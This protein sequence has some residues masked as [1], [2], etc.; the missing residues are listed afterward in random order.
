MGN[1][2]MTGITRGPR[3]S[4]PTARAPDLL[5]ARNPWTLSAYESST[6]E[7][8]FDELQDIYTDTKD[9]LRS[10][11]S[12]V[13]PVKHPNRLSS[14]GVGRQSQSCPP[15]AQVISDQSSSSHKRDATRADSPRASPDVQRA[16]I[17]REAVSG[18]PGLRV[19]PIRSPPSEPPNLPPS[20]PLSQGPKKTSSMSSL[21]SAERGDS[22]IAASVSSDERSLSRKSK[23]SSRMSSRSAGKPRACSSASDSRAPSVKSTGTWEEEVEYL[24][25]QE[26]EST[27]DFRWRSAVSPR[28]SSITDNDGDAHPSGWI[29][30]SPPLKPATSQMLK[31]AY[32]TNDIRKDAATMGSRFRKGTSIGHRGFLA[33]RKGPM[34][35]TGTTL[36]VPSALDLTSNSTLVS[37]L[38]PV[39]SVTGGDDQ[40]PETPLTADLLQLHEHDPARRISA[41][42]LSDP[43]SICTGGSRYR[44]SSYSSYESVPKPGAAAAA[45]GSRDTARLSCASSNGVPDLMHSKRRSKSSLR[46]SIITRPLE[47]LPQSPDRGTV[48]S[49]PRARE[50]IITHRASVIEPLRD[51]F[52]LPSSEAA[53]PQVRGRAVQR[54]P[55]TTPSRLSRYLPSQ[56]AA[57]VSPIDESGGWI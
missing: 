21:R 24:Y 52:I 46:K 53:T 45:A 20:A 9:A 10:L 48:S 35:L 47:S 32:S 2:H 8:L 37:V 7:N 31:V 55:P 57:T 11:G 25:A 50:S 6:N 5:P 4:Q 33:A 54:A 15:R 14:L 41:E 3:S 34:D 28:E 39:Y 56:D 23:G 36:S 49:A 22:T 27:C 44:S 43:E 18:K 12:T 29:A 19:F 42:Y 38:S 16:S 1:N 26:A 30:S 40:P 13:E 51:S 17:P